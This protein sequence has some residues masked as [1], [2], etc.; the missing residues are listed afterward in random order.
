MLCTLTKQY[1]NNERKKNRKTRQNKTWSQ[2]IRQ[3][4]GVWVVVMC[5]SP[6]IIQTL[7][8]ASIFCL[9]IQILLPHGVNNPCMCCK[10]V[11]IW[12]INY[13]HS[14]VFFVSELIEI[15]KNI[16]WYYKKW[17]PSTSFKSAHASVYYCDT[18]TSVCYSDMT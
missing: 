3:K 6:K 7:A 11:C 16:F 2:I 14:Q 18:Y 15:V 5:F 12:D 13:K 8:V 10:F 17:I 4:T 1:L 9:F